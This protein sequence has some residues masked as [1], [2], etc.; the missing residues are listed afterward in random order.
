MVTPNL[1]A[2]TLAQY[3]FVTALAVH[4][5]LVELVPAVDFSLKW[6]NDILLNRAKVSGLLLEQTI[7]DEK[8]HLAI[9]I[10]VNIVSAPED[11]PY[12]TAR[13]CDFMRDSIPQPIEIVERIDGQF[14]ALDKLLRQRGFA[15]LAK[16]WLDHAEGIGE[17]IIVRLPD[18]TEQGIFEGLADDG[19]LQLRVAG[20]VKVIRAGEVF[21]G[22]PTGEGEGT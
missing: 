12:K 3:S 7:I 21:F 4:A 16:A 14:M 18:R 10:G 13:L 19:A 22:V 9:G 11:V 6:P 17:E 2:K 15:P 20:K 1:P 5:T 8:I